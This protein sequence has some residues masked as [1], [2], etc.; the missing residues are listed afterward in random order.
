MTCGCIAMW[1]TEA[2]VGGEMDISGLL[3]D[4]FVFVACCKNLDLT[5][6]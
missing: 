5:L 3:C 4:E 6:R 1:L 2:T